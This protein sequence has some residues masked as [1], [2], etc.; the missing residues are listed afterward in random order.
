MV[1]VACL[2]LCMCLWMCLHVLF[3]GV[4]VCMCLC[5]RAL[6]GARI[7]TIRALFVTQCIVP[8]YWADVFDHISYSRAESTISL[9]QFK[10]STCHC[11]RVIV[12]VSLSTRAAATYMIAGRRPR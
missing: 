2:C 8:E 1:V 4:G 7:V 12:S 10:V 6:V 9:E 5:V 11:Q 3:G